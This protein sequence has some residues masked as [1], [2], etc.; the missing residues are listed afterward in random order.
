[1]VSS[2]LQI[3]HKY[4]NLLSAHHAFQGYT[5]I[6]RCMLQSLRVLIFPYSH[7]QYI[8]VC[9]FT[10]K[11]DSERISLNRMLK[12]CL[13]FSLIY[14]EHFTIYTCCSCLRYIWLFDNTRTCCYYYFL[15]YLC[16]FYPNNIN[17]SLSKSLKYSHPEITTKFGKGTGQVMMANLACSGSEKYLSDCSFGGWNKINCSHAEDIGVICSKHIWDFGVCLLGILF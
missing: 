1:M 8:E 16:T 14:M 9:R 2:V 3:K 15:A 10:P 17:H 11:C 4:L 6:Q 7:M 13:V 5:F 12:Y